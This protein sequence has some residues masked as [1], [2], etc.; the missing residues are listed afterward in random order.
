MG[1]GK[2]DAIAYVVE[3]RKHENTILMWINWCYCEAEARAMQE[4]G[5]AL[6]WP[7]LDGNDAWLL[8]SHQDVVTADCNSMQLFNAREVVSQNFVF[9]VTN[10]KTR[11]GRVERSWDNNT[12][13]TRLAL[14]KF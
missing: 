5:T 1:D 13:G 4:S 11:E 6:G 8:S 9:Q 2:P 12:L 3:M 7:S 14:A 10:A